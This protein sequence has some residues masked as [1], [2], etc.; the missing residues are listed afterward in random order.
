[1]STT[2]IEFDVEA[3]WSKTINK[4][5]L[6]VAGG[7]V[8]DFSGDA[9]VNAAN[10]GGLGG[11][12]VDGAINKKGGRPLEEAREALPIINDD[13]SGSASSSAKA[14]RRPP[15]KSNRKANRGGEQI[16][17]PTG[18]ARV[19]I[20]GN[21]DAK[22]VI[23]AVG[24]VFSFPDPTHS[25]EKIAKIAEREERQ[26]RKAYQ[27]SV[28]LG[29][30]KNC[31]SIAFSLLSAGVFRGPREVDDVLNIGWRAVEDWVSDPAN[32]G[33]FKDGVQIYF[34]G[35]TPKEQE[36]LVN[37]ASGGKAT[38]K[39]KPPTKEQQAAEERFERVAKRGGLN[40]RSNWSG[41]DW[42][43]DWKDW[44]GQD[45]SGEWNNWSSDWK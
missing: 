25:P 14:S 39:A 35:F 16:R 20:G 40:A 7:S 22:W 23:H 45:W 34:V 38:H 5:R 31:K 30:Q 18:H 11:G 9:I 2:K 6:V 28:A 12:G 4:C 33:L 41:Q 44:S 27:R 32:A 43:S 21:L 29:A 3:I 24:P 42:S 10:V 26:L 36:K 17:I 19:T 8:V 13:D 15:S 37:I 1:M